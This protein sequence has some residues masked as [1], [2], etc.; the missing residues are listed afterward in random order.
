VRIAFIHSSSAQP[1]A[2]EDISLSSFIYFILYNSE[3]NTEI[4]NLSEFLK[5]AI[6]EYLN[7]END[8][9]MPYVEQAESQEIP[10]SISEKIN[11]ARSFGWQLVDRVQAQN[12]WREWN[13]FTRKTLKLNENDIAIVVNGRVSTLI[14]LFISRNYYCYYLQ[15]SLIKGCG[16]FY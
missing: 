4:P 11:P 5:E 13:S 9:K 14:R 3:K 8:V 1:S 7:V 10:V 6:E 16:A 12:Y 2:R 15:I